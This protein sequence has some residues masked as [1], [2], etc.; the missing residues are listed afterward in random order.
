MKLEDLT[1]EEGE[2]ILAARAKDAPKPFLAPTD[3]SGRPMVSDRRFR[4]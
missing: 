3:L 2:A 4:K 1:P